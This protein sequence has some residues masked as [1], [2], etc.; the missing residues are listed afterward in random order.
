MSDARSTEELLLERYNSLTRR[1][2]IQD[3]AARRLMF[4]TF[5]RVLGPVLP[6]DL[7]AAILDVACGEGAFLGFLREKGYTNLAGFDVS[8]E[9]VGLCR[10]AGLEFVREDDALAFAERPTESRYDAIFLLD[11][12]E[13]LPKERVASFVARMRD[14]LKLGGSLI[15]QTANMGSVMGLF[16]RYSDLTHSYGLTERSAMDLMRLVGF[17]DD[18]IQ[19]RPAWNAATALGRLRE[20]WLAVLHRLVFLAEDSSRPKIPTKDI[21]IRAVRR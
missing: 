8:P 4:R 16:H 3:Q 11:I 21:L 20:V 14:R 19:I 12:V 1:P 9:N 17:P 2:T 13:H 6:E 15:I 18:A 7:G 10:A 5:K